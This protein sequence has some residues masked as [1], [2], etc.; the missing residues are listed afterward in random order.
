T[1]INAEGGYNGNSRQI[2]Y[3]ILTRREATILRYRIKDIDS[4]AFINIIDSKEIIGNGFKA[5]EE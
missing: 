5:I 2:I 3:T 1:I 4:K